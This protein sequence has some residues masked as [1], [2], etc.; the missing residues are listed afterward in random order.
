MRT[1]LLRLIAVM[2]FG[3]AVPVLVGGCGPGAEIVETPAKQGAKQL[4]RAAEQRT[5]AEAAEKTTKEAAAVTARKNAAAVTARVEAARAA[6][7]QPLG[8][9][10]TGRWKPD[11]LREKLAVER[12]IKNPAAGIIVLDKIGDPRWHED[13]WVKK[14]QIID[15]VVIHY[16]FNITTGAF[17][18]VQFKH[19]SNDDF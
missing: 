10:H 12:V 19:E 11:N 1:Q 17:D 7:G 4:A 15:E 18:D 3:L 13:G 6:A 14:R 16:V 8:R 2:V 9:G 5:V